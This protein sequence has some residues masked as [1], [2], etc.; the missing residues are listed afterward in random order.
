MLFHSGLAEGAVVAMLE[1]A[2][3]QLAGKPVGMMVR[4]AEQMAAVLAAN[5][6]AA[7][8]P[9]RTFVMFLPAP[10]RQA[11]LDAVTGRRDERIETGQRELYVSYGD[12]IATSKL[13][14]P[15]ARV[16]T[17]RNMNTVAKLAAMA[18]D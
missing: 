15:L 17:M 3:E 18:R 14:I 13:A 2:L 6:F 11:D 4:T 9:N 1:S 5:P 12:T 7:H 10:P 16:G 8:A